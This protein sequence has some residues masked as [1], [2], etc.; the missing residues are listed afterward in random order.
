[1]SG[2]NVTEAT[3]L[4]QTESLGQFEFPPSAQSITAGCFGMQG[5]GLTA[6]FV[7]SPEDLG[8]LQVSTRVSQDEWVTLVPP[9]GSLQPYDLPSEQVVIWSQGMTSLV[10]GIYVATEFSQEILID[11]TDPNLYRVRVLVLGG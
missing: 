5:W 11:T 10:Y 6:T 2:C 4:E 7:M 3:G 8:M 9:S 1:M